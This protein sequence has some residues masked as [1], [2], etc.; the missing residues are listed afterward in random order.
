MKNKR[1]VGVE[2][3]AVGCVTDGAT[4][5]LWYHGIFYWY[6]D[7]KYA[8]RTLHRISQQAFAYLIFFIWSG[9]KL[10]KSML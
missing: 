8:L 9:E 6:K 1:A 4:R 10:Y 3:V 5:V 2:P 7:R